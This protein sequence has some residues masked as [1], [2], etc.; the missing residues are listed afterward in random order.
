M[1]HVGVHVNLWDA[2]GVP[3]TLDVDYSGENLDMALSMSL[4]ELSRVVYDQVERFPKKLRTVSVALSFKP[5]VTPAELLR[6]Q[7]EVWKA[8]GEVVEVVPED[9]RRTGR[10]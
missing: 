7:A 10:K 5:A 8:L 3:T 6:T 1:F 9:K 4:P 2:D